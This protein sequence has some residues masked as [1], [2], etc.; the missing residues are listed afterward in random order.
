MGHLNYPSSRHGKK[1]HSVSY[2]E[3]IILLA[4]HFP[5]SISFNHLVVM[6]KILSWYHKVKLSTRAND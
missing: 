6:L 5:V 2:P 3:K 1:Y 4:N